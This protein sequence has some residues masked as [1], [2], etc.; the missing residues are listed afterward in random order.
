MSFW[1]IKFQRKSQNKGNISIGVLRRNYRVCRFQIKKKHLKTCLRR[2]SGLCHGQNR[3]NPVLCLFCNVELPTNFPFYYF[4]HGNTSFIYFFLLTAVIQP[5]LIG[6]RTGRGLVATCYK[7]TSVS[8]V[9]PPCQN[10]NRCKLLSY[11]TKAISLPLSR[12][13][14]YK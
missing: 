2:Y 11:N 1:P 9:P 12:E 3:I 10:I 5:P 7:V 6:R 4:K 8:L 13:F 14:N